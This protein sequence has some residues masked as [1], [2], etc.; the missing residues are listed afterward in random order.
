MLERPC[1]ECGFD[2]A[3]LSGREVPAIV[4]DAVVAWAGVLAR[5]DAAVRPEPLLWSALEYGCHTRDV[6]SIFGA[7]T[8]LILEQDEPTFANWDQDETALTERYWEQQPSVVAG[9]LAAAG[10]QIAVQ[11]E[12]VEPDQWH[13]VGLRSNGSVFTIDTLGRYFAHDV[14][15]HLWDVGAKS[16]IAD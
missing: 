7:R 15:H 10:E 8:R 1:P 2:A 6:F 14:V 13:R 11:F 16:Q 9:E 12:N 4:R 5:P 3:K